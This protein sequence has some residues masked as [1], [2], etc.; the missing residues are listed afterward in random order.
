MRKNVSS[1]VMIVL[2]LIAQ[3]AFPAESLSR[4]LSLNDGNIY[5][6]KNHDIET[7]FISYYCNM[8]A[9]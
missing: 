7:M 8:L 5:K 4:I 1:T 9:G 2:I 3:L 6:E